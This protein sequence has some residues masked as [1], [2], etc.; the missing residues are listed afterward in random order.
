M[1]KG[2]LHLKISNKTQ[3]LNAANANRQLGIST[4]I[5]KAM[6][7]SNP[8]I[9]FLA[10]PTRP[11]SVV[12]LPMLQAQLCHTRLWIVW[13][14]YLANLILIQ[15]LLLFSEGECRLQLKSDIFN[16]SVEMFSLCLPFILGAN[17]HELT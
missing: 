4:R 6:Y 15:L 16:S 12:P 7:Q 2:V 1:F 8:F 13:S 5:W 17:Q 14:E 10:N 11:G 3:N 9:T